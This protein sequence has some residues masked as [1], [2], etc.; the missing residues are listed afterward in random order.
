VDDTWSGRLSVGRASSG[1]LE[2]V[3]DFDREMIG[4]VHG[5]DDGKDWIIA[6]GAKATSE[7]RPP[8]P[9]YFSVL[10]LAV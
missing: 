2:F 1:A 5:S 9:D 6:H 7:D 8:P 3:L 10:G 4:S